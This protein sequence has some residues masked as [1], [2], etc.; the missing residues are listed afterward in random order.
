MKRE[1]A[2]AAGLV[3]FAT[4]W[5]LPVH[6]YGKTLPEALPGWEACLTALSP[7][8]DTGNPAQWYAATLSVASA[9]TNL[10]VVILCFAWRSRGRNVLPVMGC[11]C[12]IAF[13]LNAQWFLDHRAELRIGYYLWWLSFGVL[14]LACLLRP[15]SPRP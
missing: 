2:L 4:A 6:Q 7:S 11:A 9:L 14:G 1:V 15:R 3:M 12:M 8:W 13:G 10:L 5:F